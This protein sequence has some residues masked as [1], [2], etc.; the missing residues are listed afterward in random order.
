MRVDFG[1]V[2]IRF[3]RALVCVSGCR[4]QITTELY[5]SSVLNKQVINPAGKSVGKLWDIAIVP[6]EGLPV[7]TGLL[8][9]KGKKIHI[10]S[11][12]SVLLFN[13]IVVSIAG[14]IE[15]MPLYE[16]QSDAILLARDVLD[17]Q[18]VDVNGAK[19]VRVN[20]VKLAPYGKMLCI[21]SVDIGFRG[22]LRRLGYEKVWSL[23]QKEIPQKEIGWQ[24]VNALEINTAGLTLSKAREQLAEMHPADIAGIIS[25]IPRAS[26]QNLLN[27]L[28]YE[29]AGEAIHEL[30][31][32]LRT[33]IISQL[34]SE[35][36]S[37]ILEEMPPDEAADVLGD[38][39]EEMAQELLG[40]MDKEEADEIQ[41]LMEHEDDTA[42][43]LMTS[44]FIAISAETTVAQAM[45]ELRRQAE[46]IEM[47]YYA[48][49]LDAQEKLVGVVNF[50][51]LLISNPDLPV[52]EL[53]TEQLKTVTV[54]AEPEDVLELLAKY[55]LVAVPVL[56]DDRTM[57]GIITIDDV[58]ELFLPYA[59]KRRRYPS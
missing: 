57:A 26:I 46:E 15:K 13:P 31:P 53:M 2:L 52:S 34:D 28:D 5:V 39:P 24:F 35:Q 10:A 19:V 4:M 1:M 27:N 7:V 37:D 29:T 9:K 55:N 30:E 11:W 45:E 50:R 49:V 40:L 21:F 36:A 41:E 33:Q 38:L 14:A 23:V 3:A 17:K 18:I 6:G 12:H 25:S 59:L 16:R 47:L 51:D 42:G 43:G 58:V 56:E 54:D 8:I 22:L 32:E 44:E 48:Y 20:D